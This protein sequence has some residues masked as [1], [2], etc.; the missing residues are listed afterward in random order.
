MVIVCYVKCDFWIIAHKNFC[1][2]Y[3]HVFF[4]VFIYLSLSWFCFCFV[5][6]CFFC[7]VLFCFIFVFLFVFF[8]SCSFLIFVCFVLFCCF[9]F[10]FLFVLLLVFYVEFHR[11]EVFS[12]VNVLVLFISSILVFYK[13]V[14]KCYTI[15]DK[16]LWRRRHIIISEIYP[17]M[18]PLHRTIFVFYLEETMIK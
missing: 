10:C 3:V 15:L 9:R 6:F 2:Q 17:T 4:S 11:Y 5:L 8:F 16:E 13:S 7:F 14:V 12:R 18:W 1:Q